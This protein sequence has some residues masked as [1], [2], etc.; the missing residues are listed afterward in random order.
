MEREESVG[1]EVAIAA[2]LAATLV[3]VVA[4]V[5]MRRLAA[6]RDKA[7]TQR[8]K[9]VAEAAEVSQAHIQA[10]QRLAQANEGLEAFVRSA[11]HDLKAPIRHIY[12]F[13]DFV[14]QGA[15]DRLTEEERQDLQRVMDAATRMSALLDSLLRFAKL[16]ATSLQ[17]EEFSLGDA[18]DVVVSQLPDE[19]RSKV[20]Y[21]DLTTIY[22]DRVLLSLV[23]QNLIENGLK[24][25]ADPEV[26]RVVIE[27][28]SS[29][30]E[31]CVSVIDNGIGV[32]TESRERI[33]QPGTRA[34]PES[35]FSG[36]GFGLA[37]CA[38]IIQAHQG[39]I[40]IESNDDGGSTFHFGVPTKV[41]SEKA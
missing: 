26:A 32:P 30:E 21:S 23:L 37:A 18:V 11:S 25:V 16:G 12:G 38:R 1:T 41:H 35:E 40:W 24:Y 17:P 39:K 28:E 6:E 20:I 5:R 34:V 15:G 13:C 27:S 2:A 31:T 19:Q 4:T 29:P 14:R 10:N 3:A 7:V 22:G 9:A 8:D 33:F 36:S